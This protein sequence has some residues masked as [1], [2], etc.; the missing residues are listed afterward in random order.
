MVARIDSLNNAP[1]PPVSGSIYAVYLPYMAISRARLSRNLLILLASPTELAF[2]PK[3]NALEVRWD[4]S[5]FAVS[6][7]FPERVSHQRGRTIM[8]YQLDRHIIE[9]RRG[10][11]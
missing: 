3:I 8:D 2:L 6:Y 1:R 11:A 9:S 4:T 5:S 10:R 7:T